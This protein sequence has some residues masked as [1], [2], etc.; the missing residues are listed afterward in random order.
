MDTRV[1]SALTEAKA[2]LAE[3]IMWVRDDLR[4]MLLEQADE[5]KR[6]QAVVWALTQL[7]AEKV[8]VSPDDLASRISKAVSEVGG[9]S[10]GR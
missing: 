5:I 3:D 10:H 8:G 4:G 6:L 7:T 2:E 1:L 9:P